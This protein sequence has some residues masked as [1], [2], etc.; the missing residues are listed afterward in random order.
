MQIR[1]P[2]KMLGYLECLQERDGERDPNK[3]GKVLDFATAE[4]LV[5]FS[6][7]DSLNTTFIRQVLSPPERLKALNEFAIDQL[8]SLLGHNTAGKFK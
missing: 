3:P 8:R 7:I 2:V 1:R 5:A 4:Q 6:N